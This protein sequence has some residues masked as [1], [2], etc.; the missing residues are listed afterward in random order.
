ML[1]GQASE[2]RRCR[3]VAKQPQGTRIVARDSEASS[4]TGRGELAGGF[5]T[6]L[7][8]QSNTGTWACTASCGKRSTHSTRGN[9]D[10]PGR[11]RKTRLRASL[12]EG[13]G[14]GGREGRCEGGK[15]GKREGERE[16]GREGEG[17]LQRTR[18]EQHKRPTSRTFFLLK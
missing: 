12:R 1:D 6:R 16:G 18:L 11:T 8:W 2:R 4:A 17:E 9:A 7:N 3:H 14:E 15:E 13:E 5:A 10:A